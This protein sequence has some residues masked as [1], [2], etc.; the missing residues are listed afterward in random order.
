MPHEASNGRPVEA[1]C[2]RRGSV[3][4]VRTDFDSA[5][6]EREV[7]S[8]TFWGVDEIGFLVT[9]VLDAAIRPGELDPPEHSCIDSV[10]RPETGSYK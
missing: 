2:F 8:A 6:A 10:T 4:V 1:K 7:R 3:A 9:A 5:D